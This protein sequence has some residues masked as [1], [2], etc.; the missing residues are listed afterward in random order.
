M[1]NQQSIPKTL[2]CSGA[3]GSWSMIN[4]EWFY[5]GEKHNGRPLYRRRGRPK[6][7]FIRWEVEDDAAAGTHASSWTLL[8]SGK[9]FTPAIATRPSPQPRVG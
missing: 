1:G 9:Q 3:E 6:D 4:D 8:G 7:C 2:R 5:D